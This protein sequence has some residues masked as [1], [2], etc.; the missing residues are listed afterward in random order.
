MRRYV[1]LFLSSVLLSWADKPNLLLLKQY[2]EEINVTGWLI[3][4][5]LDGVRAYWNGKEL[6]SRSGKVFAVPKS[7]THGFPPFEIDGE[8]WT[9]R[10]DFENI[11]SIVN[12]TTPDQ[13]WQEI[14]YHIFEVPHQ[15]GGLMQ[16]L[17]VLDAWLDKHPKTA[18]R[19]IPQVPCQNG[20]HLKRLLREVES[21]GAEGLVVR[22]PS[23]E[24][25][26]ARTSKA[27]KVKSFQ[28]DE[29]QVVGYTQGHGKYA[30][31]VGALL[32]QL[33]NNKTIKIGTGLSVEERTHPPKLGS[34]VTFKYHGLT[35]YG[36]PRFP[37]F[38]R[39]REEH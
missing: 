1:W 23:V 17:R 5:K 18:I 13:R 34:E 15:E 31:L 24:Y 3:S 4:E 11:V 19:I 27:L 37:V 9:T 14:R 35:K 26:D 29:C 30:G 32:C 20:T 38:L 2:N 16:R 22:D 36:N 39:M 8:L 33:D 21:Q 7:F 12:S 6:I 10:G 25:I 28:D